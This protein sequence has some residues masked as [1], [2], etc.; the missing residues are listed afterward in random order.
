MDNAELLA[1]LADIHLPAPVS[2]WP[3]A[4]GWWILG[5]LLLALLVLATM[6]LLARLRQQRIRRFALAELDRIYGEYR[7]AESA[8]QAPEAARLL[9]V[10]ELNAVL[11]RVALWHYPDAGIASLGGRAWVDF[12]REKGDASRIT[13]EIAGA[14]REG[15]FM[16]H[17]EV[18]V[19][20]LRE[21]GRHWIG[22]LYQ[23]SSVTGR[24]P[25]A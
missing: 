18:D 23:P 13:E 15:R 4:P 3:P 17:C 11:R 24:K 21:F 2:L 16:P 9:F 25:H 10:N 5:V 7:A 12:I 22:S 6:R 19:E 20:A 1:Q 8:G 14:L